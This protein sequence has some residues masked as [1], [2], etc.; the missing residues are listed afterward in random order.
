MFKLSTL[1]SSHWVSHPLFLHHIRSVIHSTSHR[2][3]HLL[4][5]LPQ[6]HQVS[7]PLFLHLIRSA[8][9]C[10]YYISSGQSST[11]HLILS[12]LV[13]HPSYN[14]IRSV[15]HSSSQ[16]V[17]H[18]LFISFGQSST[19]HLIRS[20]IHSSSHWVSHPLFIL[21]CQ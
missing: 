12:V 8:V 4:F 15:I 3:R 18:P 21:S 10:P 14:L 16:W 6:S 5:L 17:S 9:I 11:L 7:H 19:F 13:I 2:V 20:V 1:P